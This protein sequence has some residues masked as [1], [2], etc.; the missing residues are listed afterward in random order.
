VQKEAWQAGYWVRSDKL[1]TRS[2][3]LDVLTLRA[4]R[5]A[6]R[7]LSPAKPAHEIFDNQVLPH[8]PPNAPSRDEETRI[9]LCTAERDEK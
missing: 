8:E 4:F 3:L 1:D 6:E 7:N 2:A 9:F 5:F